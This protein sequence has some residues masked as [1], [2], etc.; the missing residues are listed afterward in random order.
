MSEISIFFL[1][2][3]SVADSFLFVLRVFCNVIL[4]DANSSGDKT[5]TF[6][7][8]VYLHVI[9]LICNVIIMLSILM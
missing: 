1:E 6:D 7:V 8:Y 9:L 4:K 3:V 5:S 2:F